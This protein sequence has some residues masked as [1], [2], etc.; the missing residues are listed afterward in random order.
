[1]KR[2]YTDAAVQAADDGWAVALDG[3]PVRTQAGRRQI[4]PSESLAGM[5]AQEWRAQGDQ[6][7]PRSFPLRDLVDVAI[8]QVRP[9]RAGAIGK[10]LRYAETDT[11]CYRAEPDEPLFHRQQ[12]DW[13]PPLTGIE[14]RHGLRFD[15]IGG[16]GYRP[17]P[18][19]TLDRLRTMLEGENEFALAG[20]TTLASLAASL[21]LAIAALEDGA[22]AA[23]LFTASNLEEDWQAEQWGWDEAAAERRETRRQTFLQ[24]ARFTQAARI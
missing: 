17:Q 12:Q 22:D 2:F 23:A 4:V 13:E 9:D 8:D 19:A 20:L 16:V 11:L 10:L 1:M 24:A 18:A 15:R 5:L 21:T 6:I 7:D 14:A 3:R